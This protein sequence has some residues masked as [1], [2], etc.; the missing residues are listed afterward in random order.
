LMHVRPL[1]DGGFVIVSR[2]LDSGNAGTHTAQLT[3]SKTAKNEI[4]WGC[5]VI[6]SVPGRPDV[7][8][9]T[10]LSQVGSSVPSFLAQKI[11]LMGITDFF[12]NVRVVAATSA[13]VDQ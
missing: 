1:P 11:G 13:A 4:L 9:L 3:T 2:S 10:S 8:E 12:K 5:N 6:R 7:T